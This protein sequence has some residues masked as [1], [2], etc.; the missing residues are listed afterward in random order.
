MRDTKN[1]PRKEYRRRIN[2]KNMRELRVRVP[3]IVHDFFEM[4]SCNNKGQKRGKGLILELLVKK[5]TTLTD[6]VLD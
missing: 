6:S 4:Q 5:F 2:Y 1:K 3:N